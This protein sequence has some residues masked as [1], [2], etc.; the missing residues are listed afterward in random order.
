MQVAQ[1]TGDR[2]RAL[3]QGAGR[4]RLHEAPALSL[5]RT[6]HARADAI[7]DAL[8]IVS[9]HWMMVLLLNPAIKARHQ[10]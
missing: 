9:R 5:P 6:L 7:P 3:R 4:R 1:R 2:H 10:T 8:R